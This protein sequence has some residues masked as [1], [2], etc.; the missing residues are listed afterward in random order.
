MRIGEYSPVLLKNKSQTVFI[1]LN[2]SV[3][4]GSESEKQ[5]DAASQ[6]VRGREHVLELARDGGEGVL[7]A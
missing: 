4:R 2:Q 1:F 3:H 5:E 7:S 6:A